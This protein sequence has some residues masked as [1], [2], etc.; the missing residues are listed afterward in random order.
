MPGDAQWS[1]G[2]TKVSLVAGRESPYNEVDH[3]WEDIEQLWEEVALGRQKGFRGSGVQY[4]R[5][6][7]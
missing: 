2:Y 7:Q 5:A 1:P 4:Y 6:T 3:H